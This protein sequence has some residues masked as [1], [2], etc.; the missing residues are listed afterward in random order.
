MPRR[1]AAGIRDVGTWILAGAL[2]L[3]AWL[4]VAGMRRRA[5]RRC[6]AERARARA[7][8]S[9]MPLVSSHLRGQSA[10]KPDIWREEREASVR[11]EP[12]A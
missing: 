5:A 7:R 6:A 9:R 10:Q 3:A 2:L 11:D 1:P 12:A 4:G 8:R